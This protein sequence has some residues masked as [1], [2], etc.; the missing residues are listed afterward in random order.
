MNRSRVPEAPA[1]YG[2]LATSLPRI[3]QLTAADMKNQSDTLGNADA[4]KVLVGTELA[5]I[6]D[7]EFVER[8][9]QRLQA[10]LQLD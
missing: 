8:N 10:Q 7:L 4:M 2:L 5:T 9:L 3:L 1:F 6:P